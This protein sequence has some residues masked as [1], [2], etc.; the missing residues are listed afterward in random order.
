MP[1]LAGTEGVSP[2]GGAGNGASPT[3]HTQSLLWQ[4]VVVPNRSAIASPITEIPR[5]TTYILLPP[6]PYEPSSPPDMGT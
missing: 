2:T 3:V 1:A 4:S 6:A 5:R